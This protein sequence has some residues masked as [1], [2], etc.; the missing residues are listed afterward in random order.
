VIA[1]LVLWFSSGKSSALIFITL[2]SLALYLALDP[3]ICPLSVLW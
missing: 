3:R 1:L 2:Y